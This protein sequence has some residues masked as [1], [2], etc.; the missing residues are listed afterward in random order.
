M[1]RI[2][3]GLGKPLLLI[4]GL[5]AGSCATVHYTHR[6]VFTMANSSL[7]MDNAGTCIP[8]H[9]CESGMADATAGYAYKC[10]T[11]GSH[12]HAKYDSETGQTKFW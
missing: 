8:C 12:F 10:Q 1:I 4:F 6:G 9:V 2:L 7:P 11:C 3:V 5:I